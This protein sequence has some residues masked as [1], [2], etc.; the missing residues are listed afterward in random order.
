MKQ[1]S[2]E[3]STHFG[4]VSVLNSRICFL[5]LQLVSQAKDSNAWHRRQ[6][7]WFR[8]RSQLY[9]SEDSVQ[10]T[11]GQWVK[12]NKTKRGRQRQT[13]SG[14]NTGIT[15]TPGIKGWNSRHK[16]T[17]MKWQ[18]QRATQGLCMTVCFSKSK[19][20][21]LNSKDSMSSNASEGQFKCPESSEFYHG[22]S[23][24]HSEY[25]RTSM[26]ILGMPEVPRILCTILSGSFETGTMTQ[27]GKFY[28]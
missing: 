9:F 1:S 15:G 24:L 20:V 2:T 4:L 6:T 13:S 3:C 23:L 21:K 17:K 11:G 26:C 8:I 22:Q 5:M 25:S 18:T 7:G 14:L 27:A 28:Q 12:A 19:N 10:Q 16:G